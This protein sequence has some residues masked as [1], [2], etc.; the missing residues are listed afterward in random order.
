MEPTTLAQLIEQAGGNAARMLRQDPMGAYPIPLPAEYS[1]W[2]DEQEAWFNTGV[3]F[4]QSF[5]MSDVY[6]KGPD[7]KRLFSETGVNSF[8]KFGKYKAKQFVATNYTGRHIADAICF[9][10][11]DD[12]YALV[13]VPAAADWVQ[14]RALTGGYDVEVTRDDAS[15]INPNKRLLFRYQVQGPNALKI[16]EKASNGT[17]GQIK[18]FNIGEFDVAGVRVRALNHTMIGVPGRE[19]TGLEM[20]GPVDDGPRVLDA[21]RAAGAEFGMREGGAMSYV[22][23]AIESGWIPIVVP[24]IYTGDEMKP[25]REAC[26]AFGFEAHVSLGGSFNSDNIEDYYVTPYDLGYGRVVNFD[27]DFIGREGL[28]KIKEDP[29]KRKVWLTWN[30]DDVAALYKS[31]LT[32]GPER[33]KYLDTPLATYS[34]AHYDK[35][36]SGDDLV[37]F[38][39]WTGY[40]VN[41]GHWVSLGMVD[42]EF[43]QDGAGVIVVWGD[44]ASASYRPSVESHK[45]FRVRA[46]ISTRPL[47]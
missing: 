3:L 9:G 16:V 43:A 2:R 32:G 19:M 29:Q 42:E 28:Q 12:E 6:F 47:V 40:T 37:G 21:L 10:I 20:T 22:T 1:N 7:V 27:H 4:D 41:H 46:T 35:V 30:D 8:E 18:F 34:I 38:S 24:A 23:T 25:Y 39:N 14:F 31:S 33:A 45:E 26:P 17:L 13:G 5:H 36:L 11:E 15:F 44:E